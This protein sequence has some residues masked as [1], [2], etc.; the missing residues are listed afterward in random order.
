MEGIM[1]L[2]QT[3]RSQFIFALFLSSLVSIGLFIYGAWKD[4]SFGDDYLVFNLF[5]A[6]IP[7]VFAMRLIVV[8]RHKLWSSWEALFLTVLWLIFLPNS[9]YMISDFIHLQDSSADRVLYD[10]VMFSSFIYTAFLLGYSSLYP[11]HL[12]LR[13]RLSSH[14]AT[15]W[16]A[17]TLF[18]SSVAIYAGRDLRWNSW[19][20]FTNPGGLLLDMSNRLLHPDAYPEML[21]TIISFFVLLMSMYNLVWRGARAL[22]QSAAH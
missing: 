7:L 2:R 9:F 4:R 18:I 11:I 16:I 6:W 14:A 3:P 13:K 15:G 22:R 8:L 21:V 1:A 12:E 10:A 20:V 17:I 19:N 5:L